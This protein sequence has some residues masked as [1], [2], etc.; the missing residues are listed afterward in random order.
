MAGQG[1]TAPRGGAG[2]KLGTWLRAHRLEA[3]GLG[4]GGVVVL[5]LYVRSKKS[6]RSVQPATADTTATDLQSQIDQLASELGALAGGGPPGQQLPGSTVAVGAPNPAVDPNSSQISPG[7][8]TTAPAP[9]SL[10]VLGSGP[11][12]LSS[13]LANPTNPLAPVLGENTVSNPPGYAASQVEANRNPVTGLS[14]YTPS[15]SDLLTEQAGGLQRYL[16]G[17][18]GVA[19]GE[20]TVDASSVGSGP[21]VPLNQRVPGERYDAN[22]RVIA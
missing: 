12:S 2:G 21:V 14:T 4:A 22:G 6:S 17:V 9:G 3:G 13:L 19:G 10:S 11:G 20:Y 8:G 5:A 18:P 1:G 7:T 15:A 16:V